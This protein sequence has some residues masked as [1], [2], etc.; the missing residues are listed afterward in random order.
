MVLLL[1]HGSPTRRRGIAVAQV[2]GRWFVRGG[3]FAGRV[4]QR[5]IQVSQRSTQPNG[6]GGGQDATDQTHQPEG[7]DAQDKQEP[8][9]LA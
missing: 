4:A 3:G 6:G 8:G 2:I 1:W 5:R 7:E 9:H